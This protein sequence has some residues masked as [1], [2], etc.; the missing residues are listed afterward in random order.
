LASKAREIISQASQ[1]A[2]NSSN[3]LMHVDISALRI[4]L[5]SQDC[6]ARHP[7]KTIQMY[8]QDTVYDLLEGGY[9]WRG[10]ARN[11]PLNQ[12]GQPGLG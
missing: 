12:S 11:N 4:T 9:P 8:Y 7:L 5:K 3:A 10:S 2:C 1:N 6:A